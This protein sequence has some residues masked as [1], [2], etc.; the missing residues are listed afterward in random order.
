MSILG[1]LT[2]TL[3]DVVRLPIDATIDLVSGGMTQLHTKDGNLLS[4][5]R[6]KS[7]KDNFDDLLDEIDD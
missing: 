5:Q 7:L 3:V 1:K 4:Q 6:A 2:K